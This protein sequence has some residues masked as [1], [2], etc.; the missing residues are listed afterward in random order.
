MNA[1]CIKVS[2]ENSD[3]VSTNHRFGITIMNSKSVRGFNYLPSYARNSI[4]TWRDYKPEIVE[5][6]LSYAKRLNLNL[7]R[8][9]L[10]FV[11]YENDPDEFLKNFQHFVKTAWSCGIHTMPVV[12]DACFDEVQPAYDIDSLMWVSNPGTEQW[13]EDFYSKGEPYCRALV[14][15]MRVEEGIFL[16][17]IMNEPSSNITIWYAEGDEKQR[18]EERVWSFVRHF[19][20]VLHTADGRRQTATLK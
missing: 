18:R 14:D 12:W 19:S 10:S 5:K 1:T 4:E 2:A 3:A 20:D 8:V 16:W 17:D 6:E 15:V 11:V 13:D 7:A 9:F